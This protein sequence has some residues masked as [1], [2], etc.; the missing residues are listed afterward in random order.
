MFGTADLEHNNSD[1]G[2][3]LTVDESSSAYGRQF[4]SYGLPGKNKNQ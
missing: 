2:V 1:I 4:S 3:E